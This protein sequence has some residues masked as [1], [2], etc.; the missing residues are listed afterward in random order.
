MH[1]KRSIPHKFDEPF[2]A[3]KARLEE[4]L[5]K[6]SQEQQ[7]GLIE[8]KLHEIETAVRIVRWLGSAELQAPK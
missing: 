8:R 7:R 1:R 2:S 6:T 3:E 5:K 4:Q